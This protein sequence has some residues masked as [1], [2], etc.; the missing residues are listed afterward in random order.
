M[1]K[2]HA[3]RRGSEPVYE[4]GMYLRA[5]EKQQYGQT[6]DDNCDRIDQAASEYGEDLM[7]CVC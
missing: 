3:Q 7:L 6:A 4:G 5:Q 1:Q 2:V